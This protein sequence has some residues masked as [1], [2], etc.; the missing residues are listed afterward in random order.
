MEND[1]VVVTGG[2]QGIGKTTSL[3]LV[4]E[5]YNVLVLDNDME[6]IEDFKKETD[7]KNIYFVKTDI[8]QEGDVREALSEAS[9]ISNNFTGLVNNAAIANNKPIVDLSVSE[10]LGVL[11]V[12]LTGIFLM[13]KYF[14]PGLK[15]SK[16]SIVNISSTRALMSEKHTEAYSASKGG[17]ISLTHALAVSYGPEI[18]VNCISPGW[19]ET[20]DLKKNSRKETVFHTLEDKYQ[21]LVNR[22]G[23]TN[24]IAQ[25]IAYLISNKAGFITGQ[26]F[27]VDGGMTKKMIYC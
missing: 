6:A 26:N 16:G 1:L 2:A 4:H 23:N 14:I 9:K 24:D 10:W 8:S 17:V 5:G 19:I 27:I 3:V 20:R 13:C 25:F 7:S 12:N 21:H 15:R 18:R 11:N 22:V